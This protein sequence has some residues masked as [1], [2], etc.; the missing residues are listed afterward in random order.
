MQKK[1]INYVKKGQ[2]VKASHLNRIAKAINSRGPGEPIPSQDDHDK[3]DPFTPYFWYDDG[4]LYLGVEPSYI[5]NNQAELGRHEWK[6]P[7]F[8]GDPIINPDLTDVTWERPKKAMTDGDWELWLVVGIAD[9]ANTTAELIGQLDSVAAPTVDLPWKNAYKIATWTISTSSGSQVFSDVRLVT[10]RG[11]ENNL[12]AQQPFEPSVWYEEA[13]AKARFAPAIVY[14]YDNTTALAV[15][16]NGGARE[17]NPGETVTVA[18]EWW[19]KST[20]DGDGKAQSADLAKRVNPANVLLDGKVTT[21]EFYYKVCTF[22]MDGDYL[23]PT[24]HWVGDILWQLDFSNPMIGGGG[25]DGDDG[26]DGTPGEGDNNQPPAFEPGLSCVVKFRQYTPPAAASTAIE[27]ARMVFTD[28]ILTSTIFNDEANQNIVVDVCCEQD[29]T[30]VENTTDDC[31]E[32]TVCMQATRDSD[33]SSWQKTVTRLA[34]PVSS[35]VGVEGH[36][37]REFEVVLVDGNW[38]ARTSE[39]NVLATS[40]IT[41]SCSPVGTYTVTTLGTAYDW[42][43]FSI[44]SGACTGADTE[45]DA[46]A[47]ACDIIY[48]LCIDTGTGSGPHRY[49]ELSNITFRTDIITEALWVDSQNTYALFYNLTERQWQVRVNGEIVATLDQTPTTGGQH[50]CSPVGTYTLTGTGVN[51]NWTS[52]IVTDGSTPGVTPTFTNAP[53]TYDTGTGSTSCEFTNSDTTCDPTAAS[54]YW[55]CAI[56]DLQSSGLYYIEYDL[57][58][59]SPEDPSD[60]ESAMIGV[61][62]QTNDR[63]TTPFDT[64]FFGGDSDE[65]GVYM[66]NGRLYNSGGTSTYLLNS[67]GSTWTAADV[68]DRVGQFVNMSNGNCWLGKSSGG[69]WTPFR[70]DSNPANIS[71]P[72]NGDH[73]HFTATGTS[74]R[75]VIGDAQTSRDL[76]ATIV[77][78]AS[79]ATHTTEPGPGSCPTNSPENGEKAFYNHV[80]GDC[81]PVFYRDHKGAWEDY[82][83]T[84]YI[85]WSVVN[86]LWTDVFDTNGTISDDDPYG[87]YTGS[88]GTAILADSCL[89]VSP[90]GP[91]GVTDGTITFPD[92]GSGTLC[93]K[94]YTG[95]MWVTETLAP[96]VGVP[97]QWVNG[98]T[99][100]DTDA[101]GVGDEGLS[102]NGSDFTG[103]WF[104]YECSDTDLEDQLEDLLDSGIDIETGDVNEDGWVTRADWDANRDGVIDADDDTNDDGIIDADDYL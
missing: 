31:D 20:T 38:Q 49:V 22:A 70:V 52:F 27:F 12:T 10:G 6:V 13:T 41:D 80:G 19:L 97:T 35:F 93:V 29:E 18:D 46:E 28:G 53:D 63:D 36:N 101:G 8:E 72:F 81:T 91:G 69:E 100:Y 85:Q 26:N 64:G 21:G 5:G 30:P 83:G 47:N 82:S 94:Y 4:T 103:D 54:S 34:G 24:M 45:T 76:K 59:E 11:I 68:G 2:D 77:P 43:A 25:D 88:N 74:F 16:I 1:R 42:S 95:G 67:D 84:N 98:L 87:D 33:G 71:D 15:T 102:V 9:P 7:E 92:G 3:K 65:W 17:A 75:I 66:L 86:G 51:Q 55:T 44:S 73:P 40:T 78:A 48:T 32:L 62:N 99:L 56:G 104:V 23:I 14:Q 37:G 50:N 89:Y 90:E 79:R 60:A 57:G 39:S 96:K 61:I 58:G